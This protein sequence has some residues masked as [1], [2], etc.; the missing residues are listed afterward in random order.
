MRLAQRHKYYGQVQLGMALTGLKMCQFV[1]YA[2]FD[3]SIEV[4]EV[5]FDQSFAESLSFS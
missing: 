3:D 4:I 2:S 1:V 5:P